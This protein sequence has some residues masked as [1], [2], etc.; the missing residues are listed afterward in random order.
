M[1]QKKN[2]PIRGIVVNKIRNKSYELSPKDMGRAAEVE[3]LATLTDE[4][5]VLEAL[6]QMTP[7]VSYNPRHKISI[8][9]KKLAGSLINEKV[10]T[11]FK[12]TLKKLK[13]IKNKKRR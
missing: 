4:D 11:N 8:A 10:E 1:A 2:T 3:V 13:I 5:K 7:V 9:Y 12:K 6:S